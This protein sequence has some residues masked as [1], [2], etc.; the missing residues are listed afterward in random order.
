MQSC[1]HL[2]NAIV[3]RAVGDYREAL[4]ALEVN[5]RYPPALHSVSEV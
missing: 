1:E 5:P 2:A 3:L 4:Q